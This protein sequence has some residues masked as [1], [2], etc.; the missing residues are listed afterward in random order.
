MTDT[1]KHFIFFFMV[2]YKE[3]C[4]LGELF[5]NAKTYSQMFLI[6]FGAL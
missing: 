4:P 1:K 2:I 5:L 6:P 3:K